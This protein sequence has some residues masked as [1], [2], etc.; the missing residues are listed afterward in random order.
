MTSK[1]F[2]LKSFLDDL[3]E[4]LDGPELSWDAELLSY[5]SG[6]FTLLVPIKFY[7]ERKAW[8]DH[9]VRDVAKKHG[10]AVGD[11][12]FKR[13]HDLVLEG[14]FSDIQAPRL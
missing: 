1:V 4:G 10:L 2:S 14:A 3:L 8:L 11:N 5:I 9:K 13:D 12:R 6:K 7:G